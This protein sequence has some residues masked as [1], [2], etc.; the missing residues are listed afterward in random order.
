V[1]SHPSPHLIGA[2][3]SIAG[4]VSKAPERGAVHGCTA[5]Q[6]FTKSPNQWNAPPLTDEECRGFRENLK[7]FAIRSVAAH[8]SY[9]INLASPERAL[10]ERSLEAFALEMERCARLDIHALVMHPGSHRDTGEKQ[11]IKQVARAL[12]RLLKRTAG[13]RILLETTAGQGACLGGRFEHLAEI[14]ALNN[15][16]PRLKVC[17][18]TC[19]V[20]AAGY[21]IRKPAS[22]QRVLKEFDGIIGLDRLALFHLNDSKGDFGSKVDRHEH[23]GKGRIGID[24]F[25]TLVRSRRLKG[26]PKIIETP[27]GVEG[28]PGDLLNLDLLFSL[29]STRKR[30]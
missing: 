3:V 20:F 21:D 16:N 11:G 17:F 1:G 6:V 4:G 15:G 27:G 12:K 29:A 24:A 9:L 22:L 8:D 23:I 13:V 19:H 10:W 7:R 25:R 18:D 2:H 30:K 26:I 5:I 14:I 28:G